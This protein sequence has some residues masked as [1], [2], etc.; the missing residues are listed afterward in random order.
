MAEDVEARQRSRLGGVDERAFSAARNSFC[1]AMTCFRCEG[2]AGQPTDSCNRNCTTHQLLCLFDLLVCRALLLLRRLEVDVEF[3]LCVRIF[4]KLGMD[5]GE[6]EVHDIVLPD[7]EDI[8]ETV[9]GFGELAGREAYRR[10]FVEGRKVARFALEAV[11]VDGESV[12]RLALRQCVLSEG[13]ERG[14]REVGGVVGE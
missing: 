9:P 13:K 8:E 14:E 3:P 5:L 11:V 6:L 7:L 1:A 2:R 4:G 12:V 10:A